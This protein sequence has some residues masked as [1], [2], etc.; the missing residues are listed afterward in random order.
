MPSGKPSKTPARAPAEETATQQVDGEALGR[1]FADL[2]RRVRENPALARELAAALDTSGLAGSITGAVAVAAS[3]GGVAA[4]GDPP[5]AKDTP[6]PTPRS[7]RATTRPVSS[8][9]T[10]RA[11]TETP[12]PDPFALLRAGGDDG[13]RQ[14]LEQYD[15]YDLQR[16]IRAHRLDPARISARWTARDR[17][18]ALI[19][20]QV[21]ARANHGRAFEHV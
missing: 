17:L 8:A 21:R 16:I 20:D 6:T 18:L 9:A 2:A 12:L 4:Q 11:G 3:D 13:L 5:S 1:F 15:S 10:A 19:V 7:R 14:S